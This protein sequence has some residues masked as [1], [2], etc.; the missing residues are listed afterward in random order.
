M[1]KSLGDLPQVKIPSK[2]IVP[3]RRHIAAPSEGRLPLGERKGHGTL[4]GWGA[5]FSSCLARRVDSRNGNPLTQPISRAAKHPVGS[6]VHVGTGSM[7]GYI[8]SVPRQ[9]RAG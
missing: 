5:S 1:M 4:P 3:C 8:T 6:A 7:T 9:R 2:E